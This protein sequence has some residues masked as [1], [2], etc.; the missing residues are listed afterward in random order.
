[1]SWPT[2]AAYGA[3]IAGV[4]PLILMSVGY[5]FISRRRKEPAERQEAP[6]G[7]S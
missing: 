1:M 2:Y 6:P 5:Y 3:L 7:E 4:L